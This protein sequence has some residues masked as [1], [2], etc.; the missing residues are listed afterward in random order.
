M[1]VDHYK[2]LEL[3]HTANEQDVKQAYRRLVRLYHPDS[4][5][6]KNKEK[7]FHQIQEAYEILGD[8]DKREAYDSV[9]KKK[10]WNSSDETESQESP[11][12]SEKS[13]DF[14]VK[15]H[16]VD[17]QNNSVSAESGIFSK[18]ERKPG[19]QVASSS[20][21]S[22][23]IIM[24]LKKAV[25]GAD[26]DQNE[27]SEDSANS[28]ATNT[29]MFHFTVDALESIRGTERK[30]VLEESSGQRAVMVKIPQFVTA[31]TILEVKCPTTQDFPERIIRIK[32]NVEP[33][34]FVEHNGTDIVVKVPL[35][36]S[37]ALRGTEV[38]VP[39]LDGSVKV[40][41]PSRWDTRK[42]LR[43]KGRGRKNLTG[44]EETGDLFV[45]AFVTLPAKDSET[46]QNGVDAI[47]QSYEVDVR[48]ELPL[49][50]S[51]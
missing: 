4:G 40:R 3:D 1:F 29:R 42:K 15:T 17:Q 43:L 9:R 24:R 31:E 38:M 18:V 11:D 13:R 16:I 41:I 12:T 49:S 25:L 35:T 19:E 39:T 48:D 7:D 45:Q 20:E 21:R 32:V 10:T 6:S 33:H 2:V 22:N 51:K 50:L 14:K 28:S 47:D 36:V 46:L 26:N 8:K 23:S 34:P 30:V 37:E 27:G 44:G 5:T